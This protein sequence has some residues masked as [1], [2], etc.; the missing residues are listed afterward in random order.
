MASESFDERTLVIEKVFDAEP[1][2]VFA[3]WTECRHLSQWFGPDRFSVPTCEIDF[4]VGGH[5][6]ICMLS[7]DGINNWVEGEYIAIDPPHRLEFTWNRSQDDGIVWC[8]NVVKLKFESIGKNRTR[9][10]LHHAL[11]ETAEECSN[12]RFGWTQCINRLA[13]FVELTAESS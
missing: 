13:G 1:A 8:S 2:I 7:P 11:F 10:T 6:R 3:A 5:Y 12:H 9:F 4:R